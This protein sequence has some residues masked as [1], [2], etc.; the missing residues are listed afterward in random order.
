MIEEGVHMTKCVPLGHT[1]TLC[2]EE[3]GTL[4]LYIDIRKLNKVTVNNKYPLP[5][6]DDLFD[7]LKGESI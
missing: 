5:I 7:Q 6:T 3:N 2:K 1:N 4:R